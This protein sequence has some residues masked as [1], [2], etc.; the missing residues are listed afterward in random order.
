MTRTQELL[1]KFSNV[2]TLPHVAIRLNKLISDDSSTMKDFEEM[3]EL[4]PALVVRLLRVVNSPFF[5][6]RQQVTSISRAVMVVG[7]KNLNNM[8]VTSA[9][10]DVFEKEAKNAVFS[11]SHL[12]LHS[13]AVSICSRTISQRI[14]GT[15][16]ENAYLCGILHDIGLI[17]E[18][19]IEQELFSK[20]CS[21]ATPEAGP[22]TSHE[23][24]IIGTD[25]CEIGSALCDEWGLPP[26]VQEGIQYHH[27]LE[28]EFPP[29]ST[30]GI[31]QIAE[32]L[33]TG[34]GYSAMPGMTASLSPALTDYL[35]DN[36]DEYRALM[37]DLPDEIKRAGELFSSQEK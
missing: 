11:R 33:V 19:Q 10:K 8:I 1:K 14:F 4:D 26:E 37:D 12:W 22:I 23:K 25:H 27:D 36:M 15:M 13:I 17:V 21:L 29:S 7:M 28:K 2:K 35:K 5:G 6:L 24:E 3:I 16:G 32:Y 9:L 18:D 20:V 34:L 31:I 30:A